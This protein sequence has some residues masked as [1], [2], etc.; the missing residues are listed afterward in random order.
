MQEQYQDPKKQLLSTFNDA[1]G[2][3]FRLNMLWMEVNSHLIAGKLEQAKWKLDIIWDELSSDAVDLDTE[4]E[5]SNKYY[6]E[7]R[8]I[9]LEISIA[10]LKV[11]R[12]LIYNALRKKYRFL[13]RLQDSAGKG[14]KKEYSDEDDFD[15]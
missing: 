2:Q 7:I 13:R 10:E 1:Q 6:S 12:A 4:D 11:K 15:E 5:K 9:N 3:I 14:A 8:K